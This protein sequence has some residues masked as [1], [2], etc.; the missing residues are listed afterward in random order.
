MLHTFRHHWRKF[1]PRNRYRGGREY[2]Y[3]NHR[4]DKQRMVE[5]ERPV[6]VCSSTDIFDCAEQQVVDLLQRRPEVRDLDRDIPRLVNKFE[7]TKNPLDGIAAILAQ[8]PRASLAQVQMDAHPHGYRDKQARL[9]E[10][11]DFND[12]IDSTVL[13]LEPEKRQ[14]FSERMKQAAD[15]MCKRVGSPCFTN[16]QWE[17]IIRGLGR[18][19]AVYL[20][21]KNSGFYVYMTNRTQDALGVD[22]QVQD[23]ESRRYIN[24]DIKAPSAFRYRLEQLLKEN[25]ITEKQ[26]L[27]ADEK[28]YASV[29]NGHGKHRVNVVLLSTLP[30]KFGEVE[31]FEFLDSAPMR[32]MLNHLIREYGLG[33]EKFGYIKE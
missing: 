12:A 15:R 31:N 5:Q 21:A 17:A 27:D 10:L 2:N 33:D 26:L 24:I 18:E 29:V 23:P 16:E 3:R 8:A 6:F 22:L 4:L 28:S 13:S 11:I 25:R 19:I 7:K 30:D 9:L 32:D 1:R 14:V 20:A